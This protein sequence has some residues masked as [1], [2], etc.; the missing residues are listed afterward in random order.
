MKRVF[1]IKFL[2]YLQK[3]NLCESERKETEKKDTMIHYEKYVR[4]S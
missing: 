4:K 2:K 1:W 3:Y